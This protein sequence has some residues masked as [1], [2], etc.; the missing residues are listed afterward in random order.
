MGILLD[1]CIFIASCVSAFIGGEGRSGLE[2]AMETFMRAWE[3]IIVIC[4]GILL[5]MLV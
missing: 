4:N 5:C 3:M 1:L 2:G